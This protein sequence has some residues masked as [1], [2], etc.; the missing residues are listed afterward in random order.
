MADETSASYPTDWLTLPDAAELLGT[1]ISGVRRLLEDSALVSSKRDGVQ[2]I[3]S[4][5]FLDGEPLSSLRGTIIA[6]SDAGLDADESIDWLFEIEE[7]LGNAPIESLRA[8]RKSEVRR[9]ARVI[10]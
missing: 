5:F 7:T 1:G 2:R 8:G 6:L 4:A 10:F 3:P 9:A